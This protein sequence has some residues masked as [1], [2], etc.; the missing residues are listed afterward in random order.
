MTGHI[1]IY[2]EIGTQVT[3]ESVQNQID[4][5]ADDYQIHIS[6]VGGDVYEGY[7]I[8]GI[9]KNLTKR[10]EVVIEGLCASIATLIAQAGDRVVMTNPAEF[11]IHNPFVGLQGD[12][13]DLRNAA[14]H[15]DRIK[16]TIISIYRKRTGLSEDELSQMMTAETWMTAHEAEQRGFV[17][18]V[19]EKLKAVAYIDTTKIKMTE[20]KN[21]LQ[22]FIDKGISELKALADSITG[23]PKNSAKL[24]LEDGS[25]IIVET[26]SE[27]PTAEELVGVSVSLEDG[28]P[29]PDGD[30]KL[31]DGTAIKVAGGKVEAVMP[32]EPVDNKPDEEKE[33]LKAKVAELEAALS[34]KDSDVKSKDTELQAANKKIK[35]FQASITD[36]EKKYNE[37][38]NMTVGDQEGPKDAP[39]K[40]LDN[41][42]PHDPMIEWFQAFKTSRNN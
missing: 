27:S 30:H 32:P 31:A 16:D 34:A 25:F 26:E 23:K 6:S 2:G 9:L 11:M 20:Q 28:T 10:T 40:D 36:L 39:N 3:T 21:K 35:S 17:D 13:D 38:K 33:A 22:E 4:T 15:L 29:L 24:A 42:K 41:N 1:F 8:Y 18:E 37:I 12:A 19:R 7:A 14:E 5:T